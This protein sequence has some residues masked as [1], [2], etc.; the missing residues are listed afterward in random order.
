[1][2]NIKEELKKRYGI[3]LEKLN[4]VDKIAIALFK[5]P[6]GNYECGEK[7]HFHYRFMV[8]WINELRLIEDPKICPECSSELWYNNIN[9]KTG[10]NGC[11]H[12]PSIELFKEV[13][14]E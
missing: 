2:E 11:N 4:T 10:C 1:M 14:S 13:T 9:R 8:K 6:N 5:I 12:I 7:M 3:E